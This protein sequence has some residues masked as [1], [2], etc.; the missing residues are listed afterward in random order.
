M[1]SDDSSIMSA[2]HK[3]KKRAA[4]SKI[5][6]GLSSWLAVFVYGSILS[7]V[8]ALISILLIDPVIITGGMQSNELVIVRITT[9]WSLLMI[10]AIIVTFVAIKKFKT[11]FVRYA[12]VP[13]LL[14]LLPVLVLFGLGLGELAP[15]VTPGNASAACVPL[16]ERLDT[17]RSAVY[18][19]QR[20][21]GG[22]G[23]AFAVS[24]DGL[25]VTNAHVI[26]GA[27]KLNT[28]TY[29]GETLVET[30]VTVQKIA[31]EK[32]LALLKIDTATP[33]YL[34][35]SSQYTAGDEVYAIGFPGNAFDGGEN[36]VSK[37]IVS[38]IVTE[39]FNPELAGMEYLQTDAA[40][41][42]GNSGGPL[43]SSCGLVGVNTIISDSRATEGVLREEGIGY[44]VSSKVV[45]E[46]FGLP[47][48]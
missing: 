48:Q 25:L 34:S 12:K 43:V 30:P 23:T 18:P 28:W 10:G 42:P 26:E 36:T 32:D 45:A 1:K 41:N 7:G 14:G 39:E 31:V 6:I 13:L 11:R 35:L 33:T 37:G 21:D 15:L 44:A 9:A 5:L 8:C 47:I 46:T 29:A 4:G 16:R 17:S 2:N 22:S 24:G 20:D 19:V 38:R 40:I 27:S 3:P